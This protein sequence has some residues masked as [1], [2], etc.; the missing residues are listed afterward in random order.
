VAQ[1]SSPRREGDAI[2]SSEG[3]VIG[4]VKILIHGR[5][6]VPERTIRRQQVQHEVDRLLSAIAAAAE[7]ITQEQQHLLEQESREPLMILD[8]HRMLINDPDLLHNTRQRIDQSCINAE[9]ALRLEMDAMQHAFAQVKDAYLRNRKYDVEHAGRRILRHLLDG[10]AAPPELLLPSDGEPL[11]CVG[12]DFSVSDVVQMWR[13]GVA[14]IVTEQ[15]GAD[16]HN[17]IVAR[18][19][20]LPALV[21]ATGVLQAVSDDQLMILDAE[22]NRWLVNPSQPEQQAYRQLS[23]AIAISKQGLEAF[24]HQPSL[25]ADQHALKL[26]AN[27]EFIEEIDMADQVGVD[28]IGLYRSEFL[29]INEASMPTEDAQLRSYAEIVRR[30]QGKPVTMRLLDVGADRPWLYSDLAGHDYGGANPAMGLRGIRLLLRNPPLLERQLSAMI[31]AADIGPLQILVPMVTLADEMI[32]VREAADRCAKRLGVTT[33]PPIGAMIEVPAAALIAEQLASVSDFFSIG[34]NDLMQ[35]TLAC[36]RND[37]EVAAIYQAGD[38]AI[39]SLIAQSAAAAKRAHIPISVCGE[40]A[41]NP[42]W[43]ERFLNLDMDALS[44]S[45]SHILPIRRLLKRLR[46]HPVLGEFD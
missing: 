18:G 15:G 20:G 30:M 35:Y 42:D 6:A 39:Y 41:S 1:A 40:L 10:D 28:G 34:T 37:E 24:A 43:L 7:S 8:V 21:G 38:K 32:Q 46:Y 31:R 33:Q 45:S 5:Q 17:I 9:W 27:I 23:K 19:I 16:A 26:M 44:M 13:Q 14:G 3:I 12:D 11:I 22:Q 25:S 29:F 2:A 4:R 36:D